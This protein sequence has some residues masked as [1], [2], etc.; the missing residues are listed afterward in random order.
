[1]FFEEFVNVSQEFF[2]FQECEV[3]EFPQE[4]EKGVKNFSLKK[5]VRGGPK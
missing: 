3:Q 4:C 1:M 2:S 5:W